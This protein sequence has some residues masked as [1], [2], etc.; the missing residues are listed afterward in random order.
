MSAA[1]K[2]EQPTII[3][4]SPTAL[5]DFKGGNTRRKRNQSDFEE[6]VASVKKNGILQ[7][8]VARP[9]DK[10]GE[11]EIVF[12]HN[13][14]DAAIE[15][16]LDTINV[17]LRED[18]G[19]R[20]ALEAHLEENLVRSDLTFSDQVRAAVRWTSFY[21]GDRKSAAE[22]LNWTVTRLSEKLELANCVDDVLDAL[23]SGE[24]K[25]GHALILA[26]MPEKTQR[27]SLKTIVNEDLT[28]K[29]LKERAAKIR[30]PLSSAIF[31]KSDCADCPHNS[32]RQGGLFDMGEA[33]ATCSNRPCY[34]DKTHIALAE[35]KTE[36]EEQYGKVIFLSESVQ[37]DRKT[38]DPANVGKAQ[39]ESGCQS[40][41][42]RSALLDDR[43]TQE[44]KVYQSQCLNMECFNKCVSAFNQSQKSVNTSE[45]TTDTD[46]PH[47][48]AQSADK[49][50][51]AK[52]TTDSASSR[53]EPQKSAV[54]AKAS[55]PNAVIEKHKA[56][57]TAFAKNHLIDDEIFRLVYM[58]L[59]VEHFGN[60]I[61]LTNF[62]PRMTELM[63]L[64]KKA[65]FAELSAVVTKSIEKSTMFSGHT[66]EFEFMKHALINKD[67]GVDA[68]IADWQP[69]EENLKPYY[70][71]GLKAV[72]KDAGID[73]HDD[74]KSW[75]SK[76]K[77]AFINGILKAKHDWSNFA[78]S[79]FKKLL[80]K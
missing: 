3:S 79:A 76:T 68:A 2:I 41:A 80:G 9:T 14:R 27:G 70:T 54:N 42:D 33:D 44:G 10:D 65:L 59:S 17:E 72:C 38:V 61:S 16:G 77:K 58:V 71:E 57:I 7:H 8:P 34:R 30:L 40:C 1:E 32:E 19:D 25:A 73:K 69:K 39:F 45:T 52:T 60:G 56:E 15:A 47:Q 18:M 74:Y 28:V 35:Q 37:S 55:T 67:G 4:V 64:D 22:R 75:A 13:R 31:D 5:L 12:G 21:Q 46:A 26:T 48:K 6:L 23:D 11:Y 50:T 43:P 49:A 66:V 36:L 24:I 62:E 20:D 51:D 53:Q 63:K 78:P 29:A